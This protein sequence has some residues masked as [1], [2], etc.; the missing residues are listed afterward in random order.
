MEEIDIMEGAGK[1]KENEGSRG[2]RE[3]D[4]D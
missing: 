2:A 4:N 1:G 3:R